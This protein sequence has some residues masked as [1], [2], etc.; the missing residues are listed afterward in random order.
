MRH[1]DAWI[2]RDPYSIFHY[3][4]TGHRWKETVRDLIQERKICAPLSLSLDNLNDGS[5]SL[6]S[7]PIDPY[8]RTVN[9]QEQ[10]PFLLRLPLEIRLMIYEYVFGQEVVHLVQV[11]DKIRHVRCHSTSSSLDKNRRCCPHALARWRADSSSSS[12]DESTASSAGMLYPHTHPSLPS[13]LSNSSTSLLRTCRAIYAESSLA[14]YKNST[15]DV[16]DLTTFIAFSLSISPSALHSIKKLTIQWTPVWQPLAGEEHR[17]SIFSHTHND[18]LWALFWERIGRCQGLEELG[19]SVDLGSFAAQAAPGAGA[20]NINN[21]AP[22]PQAQPQAQAQAH[23][24]A[25]APGLI[26]GNRL[27]LSISE[28]WV[29]PLLSLRGLKDFELGITVK[30]DAVAKEVL[31]DGLVRDA[32]TLRDHLRTVMCS[33]RG[34]AL[35]SLSLPG[36]RVQDLGVQVELWRRC[37]VE[38]ERVGG[39]RGGR[40]RPRLAITAA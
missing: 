7:A 28:P 23:A 25:Q 38:T 2:L 8:A 24:H 12:P 17:S 32:V 21:N 37:A 26:G 30:C 11:K 33:P 18:R 10:S 20:G 31:E 4:S 40:M 13:R 3:Y 39:S 36:V 16:D 6:S 9:G 19:L 29:A 35:P 34:A 1:F 27:T 22:G 15:F 5:S 14:L